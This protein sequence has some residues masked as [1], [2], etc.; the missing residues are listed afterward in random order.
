MGNKPSPAKTPLS[1]DMDPLSQS[2]RSM[3]VRD[4]LSIDEHNL[5]ES[6]NKNKNL[7][8]KNTSNFNFE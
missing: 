2:K 8:D 1:L 5:K 6:I 3:C 7:N 4:F